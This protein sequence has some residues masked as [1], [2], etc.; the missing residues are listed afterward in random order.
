MKWKKRC[1]GDKKIITKFLLFPKCIN[2]EYR[3]LE[4]AV[5]EQEYD[6]YKYDFLF[7]I[8]GWVSTKWIDIKTYNEKCSKCD[9]RGYVTWTQQIKN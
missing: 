3:W 6:N 7:D 4:K 1:Y 9:R 2:G 5:F 8:G